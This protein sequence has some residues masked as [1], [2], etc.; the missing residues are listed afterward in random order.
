MLYVTSGDAGNRGA[1]Q[2]VK[3]LGGKILRITPLGDV[4]ADNPFPGSVVY[5]FGHRNPQGI[6][7]DADGRLWAAE[8][9]QDTWDELNLIEAG[10]NYGWPVAEGIGSN[11]AF[12]NPV[13]QWPTS[14][15]SPSG[16]LYTRDTLFLAALR[17]ERLWAITATPDTVDATAYFSGEFG[18]LRDVIEGP[19]DTLWILTNNTGRAPRGGDDKILEVRLGALD[20][21]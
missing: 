2:D 19:G 13:Y 1:A 7:W 6:T 8:F 12:A 10:R 11:P 18:R 3:A 21:G 14:E 17:G 20:K 5:S 4:P 9:G 15:A 16:L